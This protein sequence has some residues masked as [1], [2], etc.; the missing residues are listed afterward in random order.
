ML[1][2]INRSPEGQTIPKPERALVETLTAINDPGS[3]LAAWRSHE[4][5]TWT[6]MP[7]AYSTLANRLLGFG[8][9]LLAYDVV[10]EGLKHVPRDVRLRQM[11]ALSLARSG[12]TEKANVV[13]QQL[14][15]EGHTDEETIGLLASTCKDLWRAGGNSEALQEARRFYRLAYESTGGY[16][17]GINAATLSAIAGERQA[18]VALAQRVRVQCLSLLE[19]MAP[20]ADTFWLAATLGEAA[21]V[22][23]RWGEALQWYDKARA[24]GSRRWADLASARRNA[25]LLVEHDARDWTPFETVFRVPSVAMFTGH[26]VDTANRAAVR[27][28]IQLEAAIKREILQRLRSLQV[29]FGYASAASGSD[30]LFLEALSEIGGETCIVLPY[31]AKTFRRDSVENA[32]GEWGVRFD[33][34]IRRATQVVIASAQPLRGSGA[35]FRYGNRVLTGLSVLRGE[36]LQ[37][38]P[39]AMA[40]WDGCESDA[41]GGTAE[42]VVAWRERG[43]QVDVIDPKVLAR[44]EGIVVGDYS[45]IVKAAP[46]PA[47]FASQIC[48]LLFADA[49]GFSKLR[50]DQIP[51]FVESFLGAV[52][53]LLKRTSHTPVLKNTWGD[54][55]YFVFENVTDAGLFA[56]ELCEV[57]SSQNWAELGLPE[58]L[59]LRI[60]LH[61]GPVYACFDPVLEQRNYVGT[62]VSRAARIEPITPPGQVY[63]SES[64]SALAAAEGAGLIRC[65]YVGQTPQAK[66]YGTFPTYVVRRAASGGEI[67]TAHQILPPSP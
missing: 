6:T 46:E 20:G 37:T 65:E 39:L 7:S 60:G 21:L 45:E 54:G 53:R 15:E 19:Q 48:G 3:L 22:E 55:L 14:Y 17:T 38:P 26:M 36:R 27:F 50:E 64:F 43:L 40:V 13:L 29:G 67:P 56:L 61:A 47:E 23:Q 33:W 30:I 31:E 16:W 28:P 58:S 9:P 12:A 11:L 8:E 32:P 41:P 44:S 57:V 62:H 10:T 59:A 34:A 51:V 1:E 2:G 63:A 25:Q 18:A 35:S 49:V 52:A 66:G 4:E 42:T 24:V 5:A